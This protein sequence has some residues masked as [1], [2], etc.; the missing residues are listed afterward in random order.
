MYSKS[1]YRVVTANSM[2]HIQLVFSEF[3][4]TLSPAVNTSEHMNF[5]PIQSSYALNSEQ[6]GRL[7]MT[8]IS[9]ALKHERQFCLEFLP[10]LFTEHNPADNNAVIEVI[11]K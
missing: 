8:R 7:Q 1:T 5:T 11:C 6:R 3:V 4:R 2:K 9:G 10:L